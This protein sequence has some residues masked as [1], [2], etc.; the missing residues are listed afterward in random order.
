[1]IVVCARQGWKTSAIKSLVDSAHEDKNISNNSLIKAV[2][3]KN[4][5][6]DKKDC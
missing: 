5:K 4:K 2:K 6:N 1:M 3:N